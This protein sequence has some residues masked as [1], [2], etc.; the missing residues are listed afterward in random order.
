MLSARRCRQFHE[1]F[2]VGEENGDYV[3]CTLYILHSFAL[4]REFNRL[5][6]SCLLKVM[7]APEGIK[8]RFHKEERGAQAGCVCAVF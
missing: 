1:S 2:G 8:N 4:G 3:H 5:P 6:L 7:V